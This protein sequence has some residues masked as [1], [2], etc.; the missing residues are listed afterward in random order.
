MSKSAN[1]GFPR[2]GAFRELKKAVESFW[3]G[4]LTEDQLQT[5]AAKIRKANWQTQRDAGIDIIPSNDFSFYDQVLDHSC[6]FGVVPERYNFKGG[7]VDL[8]TYFA[9]ARGRQADGQDVVAMEMTKWFDTN[10]H[11][12]VPELS[13][14]T[15]FKLSSQKIFDQYS[16]AKALGIET[17]PVIIGPV[18]YLSLGKAREEGFS[19]ISLLDKLLPVYSEILQKLEKLGAKSI[20][21][22]EP[23][24][25]L[26]LSA[27]QKA[28]YTKAFASIAK[29]QTLK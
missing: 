17:R 10:Y 16:E 20:Q 4:A 26:D 24:L 25:A 19:R 15:T 7:N 8:T 13:S 28:A 3:K 14:K 1:L 22:D 9:M 2:I 11:Y 12:I 21:I 6:L 27:E 23:F 29:L 18:T 5:E